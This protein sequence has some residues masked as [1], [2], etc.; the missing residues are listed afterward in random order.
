MRRLVPWILMTSGGACLFAIVAVVLWVWLP[1]WAPEWVVQH[2]PWVDSVLRAVAGQVTRHHLPIDLEGDFMAR[3]QEWDSSAH[4]AY[5]AGMESPDPRHRMV[6]V[7]AYDCEG[8][9][10]SPLLD[11][12]REKICDLALTDDYPGVRMYAFFQLRFERSPRMSEIRAQGITDRES[13]VRHAVV[14]GL[15]PTTSELDWQTLSSALSDPGGEVRFQAVV[16]CRN[17]GE[18]RAVPRLLEM[19]EEENHPRNFGGV[20]S[21]LGQFKV[22]EAIPVLMRL[23][24]GPKSYHASVLFR[25]ITEIDAD[26]GFRV[27]VKCLQESG[28]GLRAFAAQEL[29]ESRDPRAIVPLVKQLQDAEPLVF[30]YV[31]IALCQLKAVSAVEPILDLLEARGAELMRFERAL[32]VAVPIVSGRLLKVYFH[33]VIDQVAA[34]PLTPEQRE[35]LERLREE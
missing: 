27:R 16:R 30:G 31:V 1:R 8:P 12:V 18:R 17:S 6:S 3:V 25:T 28:E 2:S 23:L 4:S 20:L 15:D 29:G 33:E 14:V 35:R 9:S 11:E 34:M 5:R 13:D 22:V 7:M 24:E 19:V 10:R 21:A 26:E 32:E